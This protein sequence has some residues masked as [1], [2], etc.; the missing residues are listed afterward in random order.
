MYVFWLLVFYNLL[1]FYCFLIARD[2]ILIAAS[3][4]FSFCRITFCNFQFLM[5]QETE[6]IGN[7]LNNIH[8]LVKIV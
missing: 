7:K 1:N 5:I 2:T 3:Y 6:K 4:V 8:R